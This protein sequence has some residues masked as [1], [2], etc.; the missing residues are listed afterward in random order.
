MQ[1]TLFPLLTYEGYV[2]MY[3]AR[4][5]VV[6]KFNLRWVLHILDSRQKVERVALS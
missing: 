2:F 6:E 5:F 4:R 1:E 3:I